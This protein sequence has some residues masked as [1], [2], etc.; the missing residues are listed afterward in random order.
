MAANIGDG[1]ALRVC[2]LCGGVDDHPRHVLAGGDPDAYPKP[3]PETVRRVLEASPADDADRLLGDLLD[4]GTS[5]RHMD[6]CR[7]AGCPDGSCDTVTAGAED[8]R[9]VELLNHLTGGN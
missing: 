9:G 8:L 7:N 2:D 5:D 4:T 3:S 6:C 1:R